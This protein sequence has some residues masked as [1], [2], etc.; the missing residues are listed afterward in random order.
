MTQ[1][2]RPLLDVQPWEEQYLALITRYG[3]RG[4]AVKRLDIQEPF[5]IDGQSDCWTHAW[6]VA[7]RVGGSY[8]EGFCVR[9]FSG[10]PSFH[11]WVEIENPLA[12][13]T[14]IETTPGYEQA[15][16]YM[17]IA[18]DCSPGGVVEQITQDWGVVRQSVIQ[19]LLAHG[20]APAKVL[21]LVAA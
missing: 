8:V 3:T 2:V 16:G 21:G 4:P 7:R 15:T 17:G 10:G 11:A 6:E 1:A 18:V 12:G 13:P 14:I 19:S 20:A 5:D 9:A